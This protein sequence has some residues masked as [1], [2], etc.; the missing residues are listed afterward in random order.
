VIISAEWKATAGDS[1]RKG[2]RAGYD[3]WGEGLGAWLSGPHLAE[4]LALGGP[5]ALFQA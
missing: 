4:D 3:E 2:V 1:A 5:Y